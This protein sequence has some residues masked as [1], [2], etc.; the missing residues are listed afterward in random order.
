MINR[1]FMSIR[2]VEYSK[3]NYFSLL[4]YILETFDNVLIFFKISSNN[5]LKKWNQLV[6]VEWLQFVSTMKSFTFLGNEF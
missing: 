3:K 6:K 4:G 5:F 1:L 2:M